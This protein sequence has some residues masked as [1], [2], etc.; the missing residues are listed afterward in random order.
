MR[1]NYIY[2]C[3]INKLISYSKPNEIGKYQKP[4]GALLDSS[5]KRYLCWENEILKHEKIITGI[6]TMAV[7]HILLLINVSLDKISSLSLVMQFQKKN[8]INIEMLLKTEERRPIESS[9]VYWK[10]F[11]RYLEWKMSCSFIWL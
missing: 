8:K 7:S 11:L 9:N 6:L 2:I 10:M 3:A 4:K 5:Y 1:K